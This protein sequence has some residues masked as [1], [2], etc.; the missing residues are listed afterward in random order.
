MTT[1]P[2]PLFRIWDKRFKKWAGIRGD[3]GRTFE[4]YRR[5]KW[6]K[7]SGL[8][9]M[10]LDGFSI[11]EYGHPIL[12]DECGNSYALDSKRFQVC[13]DKMVL[14]KLPDSPKGTYKVIE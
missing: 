10:D 8:M 2:T 3:S 13:F 12:N 5:E 4:Q 1:Y 7:E 9:W 14:E 6:A 11:D